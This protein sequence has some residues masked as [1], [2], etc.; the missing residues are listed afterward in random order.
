MKVQNV[1]DYVEL[2]WKRGRFYEVRMTREDPTEHSRDKAYQFFW[3][4]LLVPRLNEGL[5][6]FRFYAERLNAHGSTVFEG[7]ADA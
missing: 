3:D 4:A 2:C 7:V 1:K 6:T 5:G